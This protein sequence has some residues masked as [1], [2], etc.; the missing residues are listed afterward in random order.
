MQSGEVHD[1]Q[2]HHQHV[3]S[4]Q[5]IT[6]RKNLHHCTSGD[7]KGLAFQNMSSRKHLNVVRHVIRRDVDVGGQLSVTTSSKGN[8]TYTHYAKPCK[9][10]EGR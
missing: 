7:N 6:E 9:Y 10:E 4:C 8:R 2:T 3:M 5:N 1:Q